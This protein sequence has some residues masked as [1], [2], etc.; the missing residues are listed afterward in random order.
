MRF[1][2][3]AQ[4]RIT[5]KINGSIRREKHLFHFYQSRK[6][7]LKLYLTKKTTTKNIDDITTKRDMKLFHRL[8]AILTSQR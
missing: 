6:Q 2:I 4:V 5:K 7:T 3:V 1:H 8:L